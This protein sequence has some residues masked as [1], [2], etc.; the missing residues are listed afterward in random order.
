[1]G[2]KALN[3][4]IYFAAITV[5]VCCGTA[6]AADSYFNDISY[7]QI[8]AEIKEKFYDFI[9]PLYGKGTDC[10]KKK[11]GTKTK[12]N[13]FCG[14]IP[15]GK[16][17][18]R[19]KKELFTYK[20]KKGKIQNISGGAVYLSHDVDFKVHMDR[21]QYG[22]DQRI[23]MIDSGKHGKMRVTRYFGRSIFLQ[24]KPAGQ[25]LLTVACLYA[26]GVR[27]EVPERTVHLNGYQKKKFLFFSYKG[28]FSANAKIKTGKL[29]TK[30]AKICGLFKTEL[31]GENRNNL[32]PVVNLVRVQVPSIESLKQE[33]LKVGRANVKLHGF[34]ANLFS[35]VYGF[36]TGK[37]LPELIRIKVEQG[38]HS[39]INKQIR[40]SKGNIQSGQWFKEILKSKLGNIKFTKNVFKALRSGVRR[41]IK[42]PRIF[43]E[44]LENQCFRVFRDVERQFGV[45]LDEE[46][47]ASTCADLAIHI[48]LTPFVRR[49]EYKQ[50]HCYNSFYSLFNQ[51][52]NHKKL[53]WKKGCA[54]SQKIT[55]EGTRR[56]SNSRDCAVEG[57]MSGL[58]SFEVAEQ[59]RD[60]FIEDLTKITVEDIRRV[61]DSEDPI[62]TLREEVG[63]SKTNAERIGRILG[64]I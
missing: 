33:G 51:K 61:L 37:S 64:F 9:N 59:C 17:I 32:K 35:S 23:Q 27:I 53:D 63:L 12:S 58:T 54:I 14:E 5:L 52:M 49:A 43:E 41:S 60:T 13:Y 20:I 48:E 39:R 57:L 44:R 38:V 55:I 7:K 26:P 16:V 3:H 31:H 1:M 46:A 50:R 30:N 42:T 11:Y 2:Y 21:R 15:F 24:H 62:G 19:Q 10:E 36:F 34:L 45:N 6:T 22:S 18:N 28:K 40:V 8:N 25:S 4:W 56:L 47:V 29:S